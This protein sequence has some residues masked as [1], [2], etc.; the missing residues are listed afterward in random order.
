MAARQQAL[1][2]LADR[3]Q[4][5]SVRAPLDGRVNRVLV[6][7]VGGSI[8]PGAPMVEIAP[9]RETLLV[10]AMILPKDI[11]TIRIGQRAKVDITAYEP[12]VYGSLTGHVSAISPDAL[13]NQRTGQSYYLIQVRTDNNRT[14][15]GRKLSIGTGMVAEVALLG[16]KRSVLSYLLTPI[17]RLSDNAFRE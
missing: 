12:S 3:V 11:G 16:D 8:G 1:P 7:T 2:A 5:T 9:D 13:E 15:S 6:T 17:T 14:G 10:E 4:R